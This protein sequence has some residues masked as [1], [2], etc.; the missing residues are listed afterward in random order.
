MAEDERIYLGSKDQVTEIGDTDTFIIATNDGIRRMTKAQVMEKLGINQLT[1]ELEEDIS[2]LYEEIGDLKASG[3]TGI[4]AELTGALRVYFTNVQ[5]ILPQ[6]A[7]VTE[8]NIGNTLI[9]NAKDVVSVLGGGTVTP[10]VPDEPDVP[11]DVTLSSITHDLTLPKNV[12]SD[13]STVATLSQAFESGKTY[14]IVID[15]VVNSETTYFEIRL[16][17]NCTYMAFPQGQNGV[18]EM[19]KVAGNYDKGSSMKIRAT[20]G[21]GT[22][23]GLTIY[24]V[25]E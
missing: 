18:Q 2:Q 23:N 25:T 10:E 15:G 7:Y 12:G 1:K 8:D 14:K 5:T 3:V 17:A 22:L 11:E 24:E 21:S 13:L 20:G 16:N 4:L 9:Q 19:T 6:I